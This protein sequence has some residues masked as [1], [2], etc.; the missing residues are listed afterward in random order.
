M[1]TNHQRSKQ[2]LVIEIHNSNP[3]SCNQY[4][5]QKIIS[6]ECISTPFIQPNVKHRQYVLVPVA[7]WEGSRQ[8]LTPM[9]QADV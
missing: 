3:K 1:A 6:V 8:G 7:P 2:K 9:P 4:S 5:K